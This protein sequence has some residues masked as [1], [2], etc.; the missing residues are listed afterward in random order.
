M[1]IEPVLS[2]LAFLTQEPLTKLGIF[3]GQFVNWDQT[4]GENGEYKLPLWSGLP[5]RFGLFD[6]NF[7]PNHS[8]MSNSDMVDTHFFKCP[9]SVN[10]S[11]TY[12]LFSDGCQRSVRNAS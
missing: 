7:T 1:Y 6:F 3:F 11:I 5:V 4:G 2:G 8:D 12:L 9:K 10:E